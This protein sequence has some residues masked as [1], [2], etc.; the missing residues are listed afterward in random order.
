MKILLVTLILYFNMSILLYIWN[1]NNKTSWI[2]PL[3]SA[4]SFYICPKITN[5]NKYE[6]ITKAWLAQNHS[7]LP[8]IIGFDYQE[9]YALLLAIREWRDWKFFC[10]ILRQ[11]RWY[12]YKK[13]IVQ[14]LSNQTCKEKINREKYRILESKQ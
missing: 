5:K 11:I 9:K 6:V 7:A 4:L 10:N 13:W 2:W 12:L 1:I 3:R 8:T 14:F